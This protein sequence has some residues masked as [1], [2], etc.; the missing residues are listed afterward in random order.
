MAVLINFKICD[1]SEDCNGID[2]CPTGAF[3]W[4]KKKKTIAI[5]NSKCISCG[6]CEEACP[7][8]AIRMAKNER[9]YKK[10]KKEIEKDPRKL[11]DLFIDRYGA[12]PIHPAFL[13]PQNKFE[14]QIIR[15]TNP[16]VVELFN[17]ESIECLLYS[18]PIKEL[19]KDMDIRYRK[20]EVKDDSFLKKY[21]V[22]E[23][24]SLLFFKAGKL[25]GK[26]DGY[27]DIK[28]KKELKKKIN[29]IISK[30]K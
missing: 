15:S 12:T 29:K 18:V 25:T 20:I 9:E 28:Q 7:V 17:R 2:V 24:P 22:K 5:D 27:F 4:D 16:A 19:F 23:L 10:I 6:K 13:I 8:G 14:V 30:F 1:N 11:S 26:I 3:Y 21:K